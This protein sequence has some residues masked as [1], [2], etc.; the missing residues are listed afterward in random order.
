MPKWYYKLY[1][2]RLNYSIDKEAMIA[3]V[4]INKPEGNIE[5]VEV[6]TLEGLKDFLTTAGYF[7]IVYD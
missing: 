7:V 6:Q 2:T 4:T 5:P 1:K 3:Y